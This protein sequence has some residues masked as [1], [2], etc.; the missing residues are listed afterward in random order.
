MNLKEN[1]R[2]VRGRVWVDERKGEMMYYILISKNKT[3]IRVMCPYVNA[4]VLCCVVL[5]TCV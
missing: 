1:K 3:R 2:G 5:C 4:C